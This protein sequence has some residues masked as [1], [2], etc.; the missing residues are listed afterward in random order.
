MQ[1]LSSAIKGNL[2]YLFVGAG[3]VWLVL[4]YVT[5]SLL[6]LWPVLVCVV[7]G[8]LIKAAPGAKITPAWAGAS[9]LM[10]IVLSAYQ[11]YAA[12][13]LVVGQFATIATASLIGFV[14]F[15]LGHLYLLVASRSGE[16]ESD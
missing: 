13:S 4:T 5:G 8:I 7:S 1:A 10:G 6:L 3:V 14:I 11:A 15:G 12:T 2:A 16:K 9:A